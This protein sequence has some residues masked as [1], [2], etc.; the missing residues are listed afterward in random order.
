MNRGNKDRC[1]NRLKDNTNNC[2][3]F[4]NSSSFKIFHENKGY[5]KNAVQRFAKMKM[6][7]IVFILVEDSLGCC[8][9]FSNK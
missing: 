1:V 8:G 4:H 7:K 9:P 2:P 5:W 6:R 3:D